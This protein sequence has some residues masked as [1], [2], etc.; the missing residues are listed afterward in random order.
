MTS[1]HA[2]NLLLNK[3]PADARLA[4]RLPGLV[5]NL[6]SVA[7]L[8]DAGCEVFFH[9]HGCEVTHNGEIILRGWRD[10]NN[11]LWRIKL[12]DDGWTTKLTIHDDATRPPIPLTTTPTGI[13]MA[14]PTTSEKAQANS[15]Y[16]CSNTYQLIH[17]YYACL[18]YPVPS[19]LLQAIDRGY[20][21]G[22]RGL[23]SQRIRRHITGSPESAM[24]HMDQIRQGTRS[25]QPRTTTSTTT[26]TTPHH[27]IDDHMAEAHQTPLNTRTNHVFM[28]VHTIDGIISSDQTGRF[29]ITSNRGNA[30]V[31][32]FYVYDANYIRSI[33]IKSR[34]K[35][36]L[37]RAYNEV[38]E[39]LTVRGFKPLLHKM[40][41]ET[42]HEVE[43]FI[44]GQNTR[45]QYTPPD[46]HRTNPAERAIRTWKN[47]F[48]AGIAGLPKSFPIANWCRLT[49]Q[50]DATLNMLCP[51]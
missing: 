2:V 22:W 39:W 15:L 40:D 30:Y 44:Q 42:S 11:R 13:A 14:T 20:F 34:S 3:L 1:T 12:V 5:N 23:T 32:V 26:A 47:H 41:N 46:M 25:T 36:E 49:K 33:P 18:N 8:C 4:H 50:C 45:L 37:L 48:L 19:S 21:R 29:P 9:K 51:C 28:Q 17:Y 35:E 6:L 10:P 31:V 16:E 24:G 7:V 27:H 43:K 38:Y